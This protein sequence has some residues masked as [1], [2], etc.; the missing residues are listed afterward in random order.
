VDRM[1]GR[2]ATDP[3]AARRATQAVRHRLGDGSPRR[4]AAWKGVQAGALR[5]GMGGLLF[6]SECLARSQTP[7][8][9]VQAC[10]C[11]CN[12]HKSR[13]SKR[14]ERKSARIEKRQL[15]LQPCGFARLHGS[16]LGI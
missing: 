6:W 8:R 3:E 7:F 12:G 14:A 13:F 9:S 16:K 2:Q 4:G 10:E 1:E 11:R 5:G 15:I